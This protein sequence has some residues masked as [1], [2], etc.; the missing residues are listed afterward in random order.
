MCALGKAGQKDIRTPR[1][2][3]ALI[4][5]DSIFGL[6][7]LARLLTLEGN[8]SLVG[9]ATDGCQAVRQVSTL[10]PELVLMDYHMPH[11]HGIE[12]TRFIKQFKNPP[13]VIIV[14]ANNT[15]ECR[16]LAKAAGADGFVD[17]AGDLHGQLHMIFQELL[18]FVPG[19]ILCREE[20]DSQSLRG[21]G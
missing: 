19:T 5:D 16:A 20:S 1:Q 12:A 17:K 13:L 11:M 7:A 3:R 6:K 2:V 15:S 4:A 10:Q 21:R 18:G 9:T 8:F 14:T